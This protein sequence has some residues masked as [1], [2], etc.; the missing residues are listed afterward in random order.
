MKKLGNRFWALLFYG[1]ACNVGNVIFFPVMFYA[2]FK[3][4]F[5]LTNTQIG[6][7]T[8]AYASLAI[9]AYLVSG[10]IADKINSKFLMAVATVSSTVVVFVMAVIPPYPVLLVCFFALSISLGLFF[11]SSSSKLRRMLGEASEQGTISGV[12]Q[13][14]DG[15]MS[16]GLMVGLVALLGDKLSTVSGMRILLLT[17]GVIYAIGT[18]GFI[19]TYDYRKFSEL[20]VEDHGEPVKMSNYLLAMKMPVTWITSLMCFGVFISST[21]FNYINPYMT[22]EY[23]MSASM[24]AIFGIL[25]RYGIKIVVT[26][27][28]GII[29]DRIN[30]TTKMIVLTAAPTLILVIVFMFLPRGASYTVAAVAVALILTCTYRTG[31]NLTTMPIAELGVPLNLLGVVSGLTLFFGYCSDWFLPSLIGHWMDTKGADAY[32]YVFSVAVAGLSLFIIAALWL[33]KELKK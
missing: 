21:A 10:I 28:G 2:Q 22:S 24:A 32:Y 31:N 15:I 23:A 17:F 33:K 26:P 1:L 7:L 19:F 4:V 11:W 14:I 9:P 3:T 27:V 12:I 5:Q 30:D 18:V 8:A 16:L 25:L 6:N 13:C 20:Y 29:R